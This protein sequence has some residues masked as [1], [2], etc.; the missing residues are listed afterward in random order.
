MHSPSITLDSNPCTAVVYKNNTLKCWDWFCLLLPLLALSPLLYL[1]AN[2]LWAK[3]HF[4]FF[5]LALTVAFWFIYLEGE[6]FTPTT[7]HRR[8]ISI[9]V[10]YAG[11]TLCYVSLLLYSSWLSHFAMV[12][13][14]FAWTTGKFGNI[15][16]LRL[17]GITGMLAVTIP[18]INNGDEYIVTALQTLSTSISSDLMDQFSI[19]HSRNGNIIELSSKTLFVEEACS[20]VDSQYALMAVAGT[21]LLVGR[22]GLAVSLITIITVPLWA[23]LGNLLRIFSIVIGIEVLGVDLSIGIPHSILGLC[24]FGTAALAH[25]SSVQFLNYTSIRVSNY[26]HMPISFLARESRESNGTL[27]SFSCRYLLIPGMLFALTPFAFVG[28]VAYHLR[29]GPPPNVT[30]EVSEL[31]PK[32]SDLFLSERPNYG[33]RFS[34]ERRGRRDLQG[35][36]SRIWTFDEHTCSLDL[37]FR[38]THK[39]WTCYELSGWTN[40]GTRQIDYSPVGEEL[41]WPFIEVKLLD[42]TGTP[43]LLCFSLFDQHGQPF[44]IDSASISKSLTHRTMGTI[45][46]AVEDQLE[47]LRLNKAPVTFQFQLLSTCLDGFSDEK[48]REHHELFLKLRERVRDRS[49]PAFRK[50]MTE[51]GS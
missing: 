48:L 31:L 12:L 17:L 41:T 35:Q 11:V 4:Q 24:T 26:A 39:L 8:I 51:Q 45:W 10:A 50:L 21:M 3:Q 25:W 43:T 22:A 46:K 6:A 37:P 5:P 30:D 29:S 40:L 13:L 27:A 9:T 23:I 38:G 33:L 49:L 32:R 1:Q 14:F 19:L 42:A 2:F 15:T 16:V 44:T 7:R 47:D 20:G 28:I 18:P 36:I 34:E